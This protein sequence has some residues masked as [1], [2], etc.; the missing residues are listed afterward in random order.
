MKNISLNEINRSM[1][2]LV[3]CSKYFF[4]EHN[5]YLL[6]IS[7]TDDYKIDVLIPL[8]ENPIRYFYNKDFM[9]VK[10]TN[11]MAGYSYKVVGTKL[12]YNEDEILIIDNNGKRIGYKYKWISTAVH[13]NR[14]KR[15]EWILARDNKG[16]WY[17]VHISGKIVQVEGD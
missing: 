5:Y 13:P 8:D 3:L 11:F 7:E 15:N 12:I 4:K 2:N 16:D 1:I 6:F 9:E 10:E 17:N 14:E